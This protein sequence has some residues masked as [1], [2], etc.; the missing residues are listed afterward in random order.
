M[1]HHQG[2]SLPDRELEHGV[3]KP[4][5][6]QLSNKTCPVVFQVDWCWLQGFFLLCDMLFKTSFF[7]E[8]WRESPLKATN[9]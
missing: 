6:E 3:D 4:L 9:Y 7:V 5:L 2:K 1:F 8:T